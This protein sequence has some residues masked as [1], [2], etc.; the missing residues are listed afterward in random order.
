MFLVTKVC[1]TKSGTGTALGAFFVTK[2]LGRQ[3]EGMAVAIPLQ[4]PW[5]TLSGAMVTSP[6]HVGWPWMIS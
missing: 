1:Q 2:P 4:R 3:G 6:P 5:G